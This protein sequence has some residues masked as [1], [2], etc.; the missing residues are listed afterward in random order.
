MEILGMILFAIG[1]I[2]ALIGGVWFL[3]VAFQESVL[4]GIG[5][6]IIPFVSLIFLVIHW[7]DA[8]KPFL[9]QLA[10][11]LPLLLGSFLIPDA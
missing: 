1:G 4:W 8:K 9:V 5:C 11:Y 7:E 6:V 10:W 2:I 3:I